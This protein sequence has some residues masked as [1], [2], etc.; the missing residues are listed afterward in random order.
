[1]TSFKEQGGVLL[2]TGAAIDNADIS[3]FMRAMQKSAYFT[4]V[5]L[6][7][8]QADIKDGVNIYN[9]A[10]ECKVNYAA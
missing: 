4:D 6:K 7:F 3:E 8:T 5:N 10:V 9:F 1:L 2:M